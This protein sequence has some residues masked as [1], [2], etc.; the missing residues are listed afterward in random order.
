MDLSYILNHLGEDRSQYFNAVAPPII[1][2]SNFAF[3]SIADMRHG[4]MHEFETPFYTR[5]YNPT[6]A[7]LRKKLAALDGADDALVTSSGSAA[8]AL[9]VMGVVKAG[10]HVVCV[11][12][13]YSWTYKLFTLLLSQYGVETTFVDGT[14]AENYRQAIRPNTALFYLESPNSLTFELQDI[15]AVCAIAKQHNIKTIIDNSNATPLFQKPINLGVDL[16]VYSATKY[17]NGHSDVV[18]GVIT[19]HKPLIDSI[20]KSELMTIG[21]ILSPHDAALILRGLRTLPLRLQQVQKTTATVV[22]Y[23]ENNPHVA[24]VLYTGSPNFSQYTLAQQQMSGHGG[25]FTIYLKTTEIP[26]I[27][28]FCDALKRFI[29]AT[30]WGGHESLIFP[31]V[32]LITST[33]YQSP[34]L[35]PAMIRFYIG[36]EDADVLIADLEQAFSKL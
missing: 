15:A 19:G 24:K 10:Q 23:L 5:G 13:P 30:S 36:L 32:V 11:E 3:K 28:A 2:S 4:L 6:V 31:A 26:K 14:N 17:F 12:K 33:N 9:A 1:Q 35:D 18:A 27:E 34:S 8:I 20:F 21:A 25:L 16:C 29:L 22:S 7:I